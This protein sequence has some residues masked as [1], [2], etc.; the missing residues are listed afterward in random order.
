MTPEE[1]RDYCLNL[2][3]Y[4]HLKTCPN[5]C[6]IYNPGGAGKERHRK[7]IG[8]GNKP[9]DKRDKNQLSPS[10]LR[11]RKGME[12]ILAGTSKIEIMRELE[13]SY[14]SIQRWERQLIERGEFVKPKDLRK[15]RGNHY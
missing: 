4:T 5:E 2:C 13:V 11:K 8:T 7:T 15:D 3:P 6:P 1:E 12:M 9:R 10:K 14:S